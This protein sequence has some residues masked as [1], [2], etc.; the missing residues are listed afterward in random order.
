MKGVEVKEII[1]IL[2]EDPEE[3]RKGQVYI[4]HKLTFFTLTHPRFLR[5]RFFKLAT[6]Q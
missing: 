2:E 3:V 5:R 6:R 4:L 1:F